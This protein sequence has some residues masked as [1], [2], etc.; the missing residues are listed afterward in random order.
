VG[1]SYERA[2]IQEHAGWRA[3]AF[4]RRVGFVPIPGERAG[5]TGTTVGG[6]AFCVLRQAG[7][8]RAA[9]R[10]L[11]QALAPASLTRFFEAH[12]GHCPTRRSVVRALKGPSQH[13]LRALAA[14][15]AEARP[16]PALPDYAKV[17]HQLQRMV[18]GALERRWTV[19]EAVAKAEEIIE[20]LARDPR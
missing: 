2:W 10:M 6:M 8:P 13:V 5:Q 3:G 17:S 15:L 18:E 4:E 7:A 12:P 9:V 19:A 16:R 1:G 14:L 20:A 11:Q